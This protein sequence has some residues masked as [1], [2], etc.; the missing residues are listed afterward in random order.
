[1]DWSFLSVVNLAL[2]SF[3]ELL[4]QLTAHTFKLALVPG[5]CIRGNVFK[6]SATTQLA[7][8]LGRNH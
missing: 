1:M 8:D 4:L 6:D 7:A 3:L 2:H 5:R